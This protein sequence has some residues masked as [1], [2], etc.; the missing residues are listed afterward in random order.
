M[1]PSLEDLFKQGLA[2]LQAGK[3]DDAERVFKKLL[4]RD[5]KNFG[6]L[7]LLG[8]VL[9]QV[10]RHADAERYIKTALSVNTTNDATFNNYGII[11]KALKRPG[12]ALERFSQALAINGANPLAWNNRGTVFNDLGRYDEAIS[13]FDRAASLDGKFSDAFCNK[14]NSLGR[15]KRFDEALAAYGRALALN[16]NLADAWLG[17]GNVLRALKRYDDAI[18]T[19]DKLLALNASSADAWTGRGNVLFECGRHEEALADFEQALTL[20]PELAD[21]W[22]GRGNVLF[23]VKR[24]DEAGAA[25]DK[26]LQFKPDLAEVWLGRG[27][28]LADRKKNNDALAAYEH[29][30]ARNA[31]LAEAWLGCGNMFVELDRSNDAFAAYDRAST[32]KPNL[33]EAWSGRGNLFSYLKQYD[34]ALA[35]YDRALAIKPDLEY[36]EG[37]RLLAKLMVCDWADL[38]AETAH[39]LLAVRAGKTSSFPFTLLSIASS[40][41]DQ[42]QCAEIHVA[43]KYPAVPPIWHGEHYAHGRVRVAYLSTDYRAHAIAYLIS[44]VLELHDRK[45]VEVVGI[46]LGPDD[47]SDMRSRI[48]KSFDQFHDMRSQSDREV[49]QLIRRLEID[50]LVDLNNYSELCRPGILALRPAPIQASYLG[51][52]STM[53]A[54]FIDYAIVDK[55]VLPA[56]QQQY[57]TE[58]FVYMPDS[59]LV[60]DTV[61][62]RAM[63]LEPPTRAQAGVPD[64]AFVFCCFNN[65]FKITPPVFQIWMR[66][67]KAVAGSVTWLSFASEPTRFNLRE[68]AKRAGVDPDRLI[69][70][71][72]LDRVEDHLSR[73]RVAD[74]FLDTLPYNA[75]TTAAD[76][77]WAGLPVVTC[78][79]DT[80]PSRV[81][82]SLLNAIGLPELVTHTLQDYEALALKL[83][84]EPARLADIK[85]KLARNRDTFPLFDTARFTR[86]LEAAY[87]TMVERHRRG[88]KPAPFAVEPFD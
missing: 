20:K 34:D 53:G 4:Q 56:E 69:F 3:L 18:A 8:I 25:Y 78:V 79:G 83:A 76:A 58:K 66:L 52:P 9:M 15:L 71:P 42:L 19:Y 44:E 21:A 74:L 31:E 35:A 36:A 68:Q 16:A 14:G 30:L 57:W 77:L 1:A 80:F 47:H 28:V 63:P 33:A 48:A 43:D 2:A 37:S 10:Q 65:S 45:K 11:L 46:S 64:N 50:I 17:R 60:H 22:L 38:E 23:A 82:G 70:A 73:H 24:R 51:Y 84:R 81:A 87:L 59:Y 41:A 62:K 67:L 61:T 12:E 75:H 26:A 54:N 39:L 32:L 5:R 7:N 85:A 49:A 29:A 86:H 13:D 40:P 27:N 6:A 72:K 88:E 55:F